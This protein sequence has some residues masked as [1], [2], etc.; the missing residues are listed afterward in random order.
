MID[1]VIQLPF[2]VPLLPVKILKAGEISCI[3]E[4]GNLRQV[5]FDGEEIV[6]MIYPAV[7]GTNWETALSEI[8]DEKIICDDKSF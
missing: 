4:R 8:T 1:G 6:Q 5:A 2:D 3:Y 7:R